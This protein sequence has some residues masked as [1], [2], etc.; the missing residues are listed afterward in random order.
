LPQEYLY[1]YLPGVTDPSQITDMLKIQGGDGYDDTTGD[2]PD[3]QELG[4]SDNN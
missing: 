3:G 4:G 1:Q 2:N